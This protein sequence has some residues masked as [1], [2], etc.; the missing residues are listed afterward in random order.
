MFPYIGGK[1]HHVN[2]MDPLF[3][4]NFNTFVEVFGGAGWVS[5]K[6]KKV[7]NARVKIYNDFNP[8][9]ANVYECFRLD[10]N[11]LLGLMKSTPKSELARYK[12]YQKDLFV[13]LD[14]NS[15]QIGDFDLAVKYLYLQTQV[16]AGTPL[17]QDNVPYFTELKANR[18][19]PSKY[20]T[21]CKKLA[22][23]EIQQ[24]LKSINHVEKL[25]CED[26]IKKYDS[27]STFFYIDPP[28]YKMEFYYSK[29]FP[30]EKHQSLA[31]T[32]SNIKGKFALSY[33]DFEDLRNF[34]P[35]NKFFWHSQDVY[36]SAAT[37]GS[38]VKTKEE[39]NKNSKGTEILIMN[40]DPKAFSTPINKKKKMKS[41]NNFNELLSY[42]VA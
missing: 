33:Y 8:L 18:K 38:T 7:S 32:L 4:D 34:Y 24:V 27:D 10:P 5:V 21:L 40:Y 19:Y 3:P 30:R 6:S 29:D 42:E 2:W 20:D 15:V 23:E 13:N 12:Q 14:W 37:R 39:Y 17:S 26:L 35:K 9:L 28:Y 16:F 31:N 1:S 25:D 41:K 11:K 22:R 36:R